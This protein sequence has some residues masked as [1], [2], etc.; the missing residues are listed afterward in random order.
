MPRILGMAPATVHILQ[1]TRPLSGNPTFGPR[2]LGERVHSHSTKPKISH[3]ALGRG[4]LQPVGRRHVII[5]P[6]LNNLDPVSVRVFGKRQPL[7]AP[8]QW[9]LHKA[10]SE[11]LQLRA[12]GIHV[13]HQETNVAEAL[14]ALRV[15][16]MV[17][18]PLLRLG[19][20]VVRQLQHGPEQ[21]RTESGSLVAVRGR[22][23]DVR[24]DVGHEIQ[25]EI[26]KRHL[27]HERQP[28]TLIKRHRDL[29]VAHAQ[30]RLGEVVLVRQRRGFPAT[31]NLDP[32][33]VRVQGEGQALH[34]PLVR[35]LLEGDPG[36]L[37]L[38]RA[39]VH[40][41][42]RDRDVAEAVAVRVARVVRE[43]LV[44]LRAPIVGE[45]QSDPRVRP[46]IS[47]GLGGPRLEGIGLGVGR[48]TGQE[49]EAELHVREVQPV[50][51]REAQEVAVE[52]EGFHRILDAEHCLLPRPVHAPGCCGRPGTLYS[53][54]CLLSGSC[55]HGESLRGVE[56]WG[57]NIHWGRWQGN[58]LRPEL[59]PSA[60]DEKS[61]QHCHGRPQR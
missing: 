4:R 55:N 60:G 17:R 57:N 24:R 26:R 51:Q 46:Q 7:H 36:R 45:F 56:H 8:V 15:P 14:A 32:V 44:V 11:G 42:A 6:T 30:H 27:P 48:Q 39:R 18:E 19:A 16:G 61:K 40:V 12:R 5:A 3:G 28:E 59:S 43:V 10:K 50:Q 9:A 47:V 33:A 37:Q 21:R 31:H 23:H 22:G 1:C 41:I 58:C 49:I 34:P 25:R 13:V 35:A 29:R 54:V 20:V 38:R 53:S 52:G 2:P